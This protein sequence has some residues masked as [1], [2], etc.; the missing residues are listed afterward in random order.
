MIL[1]QGQEAEVGKQTIVAAREQR[2]AANPGVR[3]VSEV[4]E[5]KDV[6]ITDDG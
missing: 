6:T 1:Q 2:R 4:P 3:V 5:I